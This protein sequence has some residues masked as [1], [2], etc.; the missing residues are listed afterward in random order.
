MA[1]MATDSLSSTTS[2]LTKRAFQVLHERLIFNVI[3]PGQMI[4]DVALAA[5]LGMSRTPIRES[6]LAL[7]QRGLVR[8]VPRVGHFASEITPED[9]FEAYEVRLLIEPA[10]AEFAA[11]RITDVEVARLRELV[12]FGP[13][14]LTPERYAE[15]VA[16]N[17]DF[18]VGI[19]AASGNR[20]LAELYTTL[21]D[22][23]TRVIHYEVVHGYTSGAWR[24]EHLRILGAIERHDPVAAREI[25]RETI[26][27]TNVRMRKGVWLRFR[28]LAAP[29]QVDYDGPSSVP[30][31]PMER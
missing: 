3:E 28:D 9:V 23:L 14:E 13:D 15:A 8:I 18:H 25:V 7:A 27:S 2:S 31:E 10:T 30:E 29:S 5:E 17:R 12:G 6:L 22:N 19:A 4:D 1:I 24:E 16:L 11:Q 21:M 20:R 26:L